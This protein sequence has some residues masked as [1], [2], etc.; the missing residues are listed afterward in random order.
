MGRALPVLDRVR[1]ASPCHVGWDQMTGDARRRF[2]DSCSLHV[3]NLSDMT[4]DEAEGFVR[5]AEGLPERTCVRFYAR[6]D[7]TVITK[8]CPVGLAGVRRRL[9]TAAATAF[10]A[11]GLVVGAVLGRREGSGAQRGWFEPAPPPPAWGAIAGR[12][13]W[14]PPPPTNPTS[15]GVTTGESPVC[16]LPV[17][18][19][20]DAPAELPADAPL[21]GGE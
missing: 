6:A 16:D 9:A 14:N 17:E 12:M 15:Q 21:A 13:V 4:A 5:E 7:G 3:Y 10:A 2:C 11:V 1:I 18:V 19:P 8:D 20:A